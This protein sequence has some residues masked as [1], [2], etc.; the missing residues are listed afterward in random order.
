MLEFIQAVMAASSFG[1]FLLK[2]ELGWRLLPLSLK[3]KACYLFF[4]IRE[5]LFIDEVYNN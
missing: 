3:W 4:V 5:H 1:S 2:T